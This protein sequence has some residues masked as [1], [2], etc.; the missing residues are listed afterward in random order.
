MICWHI[1]TANEYRNGTPQ[2]GHMYFLSDTREIYRGSDPFTESVIMYTGTLPTV[3]ALN[4]LQINSETLEG[5][6]WQGAAAG[7]KTVISA[8]SDEVTDTAG[9]A[10]SGKAVVGYVAVLRA[11]RRRIR[12]MFIVKLTVK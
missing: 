4:R 2:D 3:P 8:I 9:V 12:H 1:V 11:Y 5:K 7:W 10:V 6:I